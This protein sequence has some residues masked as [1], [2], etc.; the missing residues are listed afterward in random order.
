M[1]RPTMLFKAL[2]AQASMESCLST[3]RDFV[4]IQS[5]FEHEGL[6]FLTITL[7]RLCDSLEEGLETGRFTLPLGFRRGRGRLPAL[8]Q[9]FF[10][11]V[12]DEGGTLLD[13]ACGESILWIRQITRFYKKPKLAC[14]PDREILAIRKFKQV[15]E[16]LFH[17]TSEVNRQDSIL[18]AVSAILW[19]SVF[20]T[21]NGDSIVCG[22]GPGVTADRRLSNERRRIRHWYTRAEGS[23]AS[24]DHA[25]HNWA[26]CN[27]GEGSQGLVDVEYT[28]LRDEPGVRVVFVP[29][30]LTTPRVI[31]IE[32]SS[33]QF[34]QQGV[35]RHMVRVLETHWLTSGS[36]NFTDQTINQRLAYSSSIDR[37]LAT[38]DLSDASDRVHLELVQRIFRRSPILEF[39]EDCRSLHADLP[40]GSN[41]VLKKYASMGSALCFP[42]EACV[43]YTLILSAIFHHTGM[44]PNYR[45]ITKLKAKV[46]V[47][48][49]DLIV[50]V[51]YVDAVSD[52]LE[53]YALR[54]NRR[55]TFSKSA[56][57]E[58]CGSDFYNGLSV[59]PVYARMDLPERKSE[60]TPNHVMS[61]T[62]TA[63]QFYEKGWWVVAQCIR[64]IVSRNVATQIPISRLYDEGVCFA[65]C[66][67]ERNL[68]FNSKTY[69]WEQ[70]RIV[71]VP[72]KQKDVIDGCYNSCYNLAFERNGFSPDLLSQTGSEPYSS[73]TRGCESINQLGRVDRD[74]SHHARTDREQNSSDS[75]LRIGRVGPSNRFGHGAA[76]VDVERGGYSF[77]GRSLHRE[78]PC[79][80]ESS[81]SRTSLG[82]VDDTVID[83]HSTVKRGVFKQKRRWVTL[84]A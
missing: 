10:N 67:Q 47:Y 71:Y 28:D 3:E 76:R 20:P 38:I 36:V 50:P 46:K 15:E 9:G 82:E 33:M 5:R 23:L 18:D 32:P 29:K 56:F 49:D 44:K 72:L 34:M 81:F 7:P 40:D 48:G 79:S 54:V 80:A 69:S 45:S 37:S 31:A 55:K 60:W 77:T 27:G 26:A 22:H 4:T 84:V 58:S 52:Y 70:R 42:V 35:A 13:T 65:S 73:I 83:F 63:N 39:L 12:F 16:D 57:R 14:S 62:S 75:H 66:F 21:L 11:R 30:T 1:K 78:R 43:F 8:L 74:L 24:A 68:R 17:A 61:W 6:S 64:D 51:D 19:S 59:K 53:S 41:L 2:L 25:V